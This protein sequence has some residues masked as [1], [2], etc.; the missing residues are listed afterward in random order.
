MAN[1]EMLEIRLIKKEMVTA[2]VMILRFEKPAGFEF[3]AGQF[4]RVAA[5]DGNQEVLR[6]YSIASSPQENYLEICAKILP[7]GKAS[8]LFSSLKAGESIKITPPAGAFVVP[9]NNSNSLVLV[10]T[11]TGIAPLMSIAAEQ[12]VQKKA[13]PVTMIFGV[14]NENQVFWGQRQNIWQKTFPNFKLVLTL[15]QADPNWR[16]ARGRVSNFV[17]LYIKPKTDYYLCGSAPMVKD[18]RAI[19]LKNKVDTKCIHLEIY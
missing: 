2:D 14:R 18:V 16:G 9:P 10:G 1:P 4:V 12:L 13:K 17:P 8:A 3:L 7:G 19:L 5:P 15:S 6:S 11:G